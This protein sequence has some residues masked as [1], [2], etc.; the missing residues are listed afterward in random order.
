M[1]IRLSQSPR[2]TARPS[3]GVCNGATK[4]RRTISNSSGISIYHLE[5]P[6]RNEIDGGLE[7]PFCDLSSLWTLF[8][9]DCPHP[10]QSVLSPS[11]Y[12]SLVCLFK[13][14]Y[15]PHFLVLAQ[16]LGARTPFSS[17]SSPPP[18]VHIISS[19]LLS[20]SQKK[21]KLRRYLRGRRKF[22]SFTPKKQ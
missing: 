6:T 15:S 2:L 17:S 8:S 13:T 20:C 10:A 5:R 19:P 21:E 9:L 22:L 7:T 1:I 18:S 11:I 12:P 14:A 4:H 3:T 16:Y